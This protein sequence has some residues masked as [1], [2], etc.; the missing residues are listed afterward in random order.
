MTKALGFLTGVCLTM[1]VFALFNYR[2]DDHRSDVQSTPTVATERQTTLIGESANPRSEPNRDKALSDPAFTDD[3][4]ATKTIEASDEGSIQTAAPE[5]SASM[6]PS[7]SPIEER[8]VKNA[9]GSEQAYREPTTATL[10]VESEEAAQSIDADVP[11]RAGES[12]SASRGLP[13][14]YAFWSPFRSEW[15]AIGFARRLTK[16]TEID[17][18]VIEEGRGRYRAAFNYRDEGQRL[19]ILERIESITG[20]ELE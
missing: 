8:R 17:I 9:A 20:L 15:A 10:T 18:D 6:S 12:F 2:Y 4:T 16:A 5:L 3:M 11:E 13:G 7:A 19:E 14:A 1:A